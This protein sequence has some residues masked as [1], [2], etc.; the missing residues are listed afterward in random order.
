MKVLA[1]IIKFVLITILTVGIV[2][3]GIIKTVSSTILEKEY[4]A[5]QMEETNFYEETH[6]LVESNFENYIYQSGLDED[7]L[8]NICTKEKVKKDIELILSNIYEGKDIEI[9]TSEI[10]DNLNSNIDKSNIKN[11]QNE[12]AIEEFVQ[13]IC[14]EYRHTILHTKYEKQ[15]NNGYEKIFDIIGKISK[16]IIIVIVI[17]VLI[18]IIMNIKNISKVLQDI[19]IGL[20][21]SSLFTLVVNNIITTKINISGIKVFNN[22]F[23]NTI[24]TILEDV[25]AKIVSLQIITL[26]AAI[27][28]IILYA[29]IE[30]IKGTKEKIGTDR[31]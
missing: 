25:L 14:E 24:V 20:L 18:I 27:I 8:N 13:H 1:K 30:A 31:K 28:M 21:S 5:K 12:K 2:S 4:I 19:G 15:I 29:I 9:D 3:I 10:A 23:S 7:V 22:A 11:K 16:T 6:K 17:D 26:V